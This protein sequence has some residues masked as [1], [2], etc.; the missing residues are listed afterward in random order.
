MCA[1]DT[2]VLRRCATVGNVLAG[3]VAQIPQLTMEPGTVCPPG[4]DPASSTSHPT[5]A[6]RGSKRPCVFTNKVACVLGAGGG[7]GTA[8]AQMHF[9][10]V[11]ACLQLDIPAFPAGSLQ[12]GRLGLTA[13]Q[14]CSICCL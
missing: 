13:S 11:A 7:A 5:Y 10:N 14:A 4:L 1:A 3:I 9:Q 12:V 2:K 8:R 6:C